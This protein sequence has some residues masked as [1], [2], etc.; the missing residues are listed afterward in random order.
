[1]HYVMQLTDTTGMGKDKWSQSVHEHLATEAIFSK[2]D[3][4][5][6]RAVLESLSSGSEAC[7]LVIMVEFGLHSQRGAFQFTLRGEE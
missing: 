7:G 6:H 5:E 1:M 3:Q 4:E 2:Q